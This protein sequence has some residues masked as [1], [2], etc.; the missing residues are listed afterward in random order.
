MWPLP[1]SRTTVNLV[2]IGLLFAGVTAGL[3]YVYR[4]GVQNERA[5]MAAQ[6]VAALEAR[7]AAERDAARRLKVIT[8]AHTA[9]IDRRARAAAAARAD[10]DRL[11]RAVD[12]A[13]RAAPAAPG[14]PPDGAAARA[15]ELLAE[16]GGEVARLGDEARGLAAQ[17]IGLQAYARLAERTCG[18]TRDED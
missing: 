11:R 3:V 8:D 6:L 1:F 5:R 4:L 9:E 17:V 12:A 10:V 2:L 15:G 18:V 7:D 16:C 13:A 14:S